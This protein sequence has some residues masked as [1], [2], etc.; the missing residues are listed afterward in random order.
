MTQNLP[1]CRPILRR[2]GETLYALSS[3]DDGEES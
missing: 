3:S 2:A 1:L